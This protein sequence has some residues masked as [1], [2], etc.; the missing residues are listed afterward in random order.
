MLCESDQYR[1]E[2]FKRNPLSLLDK[3]MSD[4]LQ[5]AV[6]SHTPA[7]Y[8]HMPNPCLRAQLV[9]YFWLRPEDYEWLVDEDLRLACKYRKASLFKSAYL[10]AYPPQLKNKRRSTPIVSCLR[11]I[12]QVFMFGKRK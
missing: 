11:F 4:A 8:R 2:L 6:L 10:R 3:P 12:K 7:M 5:L 9:Y 1:F